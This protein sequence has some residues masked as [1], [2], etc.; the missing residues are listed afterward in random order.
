MSK[1]Q[2][3]G[4]DVYFWFAANTTAGTAGDGATPL[5]DVRLAGAAAGAAPV[6]SGT[7]TLLTHADYTDGL[8]EIKIDTDAFSAGEYAVFCTLTISTVNPAGFVGS[9]KLRTAGTGAIKVDLV[10]ILG[11]VITGTAAQ[12]VAAFTKFFNVAAPTATCLSLPDAVAGANGG[13]PT[14]NGTKVSQTVDLTAAQSIACSD[15]T[16]FALSATGLDLILHGATFMVALA[17]AVWELATRT[18]TA[19]SF[20]PSLHSDYNAAKTAA[21]PGAKMDLIDAPNATGISAIVTAINSLATYGLTA[22][23]TLLVTTGIKA[24]TVPA[25]VQADV[26]TAVGLATA[27]LD[28]QLA[29]LPTDADVNAACD[30]AISDAA[31]ATAANLLDIH[32]HITDILGYVDTEVAAIIT[33]LAKVPKSD[34]NVSLNATVLA[35]IKTALEAAGGHLAL[36]KTAAEAAKAVTDKVNNMI[37]VVP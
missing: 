19:F 10:S 29:A 25:L 15:K 31:L 20:T 14:T 12:I 8:H 2:E 23:N 26:R 6:Q 37:E 28:T 21:A 33:E 3:I 18:L 24:A 34:S 4:D 30:T 35:A 7:P 32:G 17:T 16:G 11:T 1:Y 13:L 27:N 5:Y 9:F 36:T 22:L